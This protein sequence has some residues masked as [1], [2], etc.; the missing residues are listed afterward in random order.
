MP[1]YTVNVGGR[2][3]TVTATSE[4][5][6]RLKGQ[7]AFGVQRRN[8]NVK[9]TTMAAKKAKATRTKAGVLKGQAKTKG[10]FGAK[11]KGGAKAKKAG[12]GGKPRGATA[13][14]GGRS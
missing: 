1:R 2:S 6:A 4:T 13:K 8:V 9:E 12:K 7:I 3:K 11:P 14:G 5:H 10:G